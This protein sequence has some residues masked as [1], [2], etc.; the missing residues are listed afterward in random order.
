MKNGPLSL[1]IMV[2]LFWN[3]TTFSA[4][5]AGQ[6]QDES[7]RRKE[8]AGVRTR[9]EPRP[10]DAN[11]PPGRAIQRRTR[12]RGRAE[13][14]MRRRQQEKFREMRRKSG[15]GPLKRPDLRPPR[16]KLAK[17]T[18]H[19]EQFKA[20]QT[21][22]A[23]E[24]DKHNKRLAQLK[25]IGD[26]AREDNDTK[27]TE[28]VEKLV[29]KEQQRFGRKLRRMQAKRQQ[30]LSLGEKGPDEQAEDLG[31]DD[32]DEP[33]PQPKEQSKTRARRRGAARTTNEPPEKE[34]A[35]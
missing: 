23:R 16:H 21:Q 12:G 24:L 1:L 27:T 34:A 8:A 3:C 32:T 7:A 17:G 33:K 18:Q 29:R 5:G 30:I 25:R 19:R 6:D 9:T 14:E 20:L 4:K 15:E 26:L 28:R 10:V 11:Q 35:D 22:M 13:L 31:K 2:M